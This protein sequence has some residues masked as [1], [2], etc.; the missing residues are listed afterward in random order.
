MIEKIGRSTVAVLVVIGAF[1]VVVPTSHA[2]AA[3]DDSWAKYM[4]E[5]NG[6][7]EELY[8]NAVPNSAAEAFLREN[9]PSFTCPDKDIERTYHFRWWTYR[10]HI[11]KL[12]DGGRIV[13]E[14][15]PPVPW[16]G[17]ENT[18][19]CAM[20]HHLREGRWLADASIT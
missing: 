16:A 20:G 18:I 4:P 15:L 2:D 8:T 6:G 17:P 12:S 11:K 3:I 7:D 9:A 5:F 13:T 14:F 1:H 10:K 19:N